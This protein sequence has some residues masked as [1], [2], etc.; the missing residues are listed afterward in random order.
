MSIEERKVASRL[1]AK[2]L[3]YN[4][5]GK[6]NAANENIRALFLFLLQIGIDPTPAIMEIENKKAGVR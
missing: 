2:A 4:D 5:C 6:D 1:L 3:A